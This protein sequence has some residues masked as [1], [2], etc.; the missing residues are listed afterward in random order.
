MKIGRTTRL[1]R[2]VAK[3]ASTSLDNSKACEENP[4]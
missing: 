2:L 1:S 3:R 4:G